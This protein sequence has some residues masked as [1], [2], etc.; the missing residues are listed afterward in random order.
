MKSETS[1]RSFPEGGGGP[2][3]PAPRVA[4]LGGGPIGLEAALAATEV[5]LPFRLYEAGPTVG[6]NIREWGHV[7]LFTP[8][9]QSVSP[10]MRRHL[11]C[12]G[13]ELP[14]SE[15]ACPTGRELVERA[16]EPVAALSTVA[17]SLETGIRVVSVGREGLLKHEAIGSPERAGRPFRL[18]V[19]TGRGRRVERAD[20]VLDCTGSWGHP[21]PVGDGGIPA[22]GEE[23]LGQRLVQRIPDFAAETDAWAGQTVLLI[24]AGHSAQTAVRDLSRLAESRPGT[25]VIWA[26]RRTEPDWSVDPEDPLPARAG[27]TREARALAR[28]ASPAV[29]IRLGATVE[30]FESRE[31]GPVEVTLRSVDGTGEIRDRESREL[32]T[33]HVDRILALTGSV[34]DASLYRQLQ[35][36]ECYATSGPMKL[37]AALLADGSGDCLDQTSHG[38]EALKSPEPSFYILGSKSYGRNNTFLLRVGWEQVDEVFSEL[39]DETASEG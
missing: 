36:H 23:R 34:G 1:Q 17:P 27:L 19:E 3:P 33:L 7:R 32:E 20:V 11:R 9:A 26:L 4:I 24:G 5:G 21:H 30:A 28:G 12:A 35:V 18:L 14:A 37:A 2:R 31:R 8:W 6:T 25:R 38:I 13:I 39:T 10:R 15:D 22:P 16:L 29:E